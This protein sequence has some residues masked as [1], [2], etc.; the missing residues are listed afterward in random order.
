MKASRR[1]FWRIHEEALA[2]RNVAATCRRYGLPRSTFYKWRADSKTTADGDAPPVK[3][4]RHPHAPSPTE[5]STLCRIAALNVEWR[6]NRLSVALKRAGS[7]RSPK[8]V[9]RSLRR[10]KLSRLERLRQLHE[11]TR[12]EKISIPPEI[13]KQITAKLNACNEHRAEAGKWPG[14]HLVVGFVLLPMPRLMAS[15]I[16]DQSLSLIRGKL[17][18]VVVLDTFNLHLFASPLDWTDLR[19]G[20]LLANLIR[21]E[22]VP[23]YKT[24]RL[25][26]KTVRMVGIRDDDC[27]YPIEAFAELGRELEGNEI[28]FCHTWKS[29]FYSRFRAIFRQQFEAQSCNRSYRDLADMQSEFEQ[30]I[31]DYN[32]NYA[33]W[34][35]PTWNRSPEQTLRDYQRTVAR[36][37]IRVSARSH[38]SR[39]SRH[40][41]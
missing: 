28:D 37:R 8:S 5:D 9:R 35:F 29:G 21:R 38:A 11:L 26:I 15:A 2:A 3:R 33:I 30:W 14:Q 41:N 23:F 27:G 22:V 19:P 40:E 25:R 16:P 18:F 31:R 32:A 7:P 20:V 6:A 1:N 34:G 36:G 12:Y 24:R 39:H 4:K 17:F 10:L 13:D